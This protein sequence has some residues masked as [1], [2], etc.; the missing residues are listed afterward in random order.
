MRDLLRVALL[1]GNVIAVGRGEIDRRERRGDVERHVVRVRH[2]R[3]RVRADLVGDVPIRSDPI[4]ADDDEVHVA[5][6]HERTG[7]ALGD[8]GRRHLIAQ[9]LPRR[10]PRALQERAGLVGKHLDDLP[11]LGRGADHAE[12]RAVAG[13]GERAGIAVR[14]DAGVL[15]HHGSAEP[16]HGLAALEV[17]VVN[18]VGFALEPILELVDRLSL[19]H[20]VAEA[21]LHAIDRPEQIDRRRPR[22]RHQQAELV[23]LDRELLRP[24]RLAAA[25]AEREAHRRRHANRRRATDDHRLD[26]ARDFLRRLAADVDFLARQLALIDHDD[27][28]GLPLNGW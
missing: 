8:H 13:R 7:H 11:L 19:A 16:A 14:E 2:H 18:R 20:T 12:R 15:G 9:E 23:E 6:A 25:H 17:L 4:G 26:R 27:R 22:R 3:Y 5:L 24:L 1:D 21:A 10:E 28:V